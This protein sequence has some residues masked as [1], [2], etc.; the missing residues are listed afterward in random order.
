MRLVAFS[1]AQVANFF[2][3]RY[4]RGAVHNCSHARCMYI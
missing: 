4:L 3:W 2:S 1:W